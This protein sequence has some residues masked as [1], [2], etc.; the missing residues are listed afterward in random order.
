VATR[1]ASGTGSGRSR[2]ASEK[3]NI[4]EVAP[5]PIASELTL[6]SVNPGVLRHS[7]RAWITD[8]SIFRIDAVP[9]SKVRF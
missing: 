8:F 6:T 5:I 7:R 2:S 1:L 9:P 3:L 4:A